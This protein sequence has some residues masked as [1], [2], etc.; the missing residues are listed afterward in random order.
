MPRFPLQA[1]LCP[2][3]DLLTISPALPFTRYRKAPTIAHFYDELLGRLKSMPQVES[4]S[5]TACLPFGGQ[6]MTQDVWAEGGG[7]DHRHASC[8]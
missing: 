6:L 1:N 7:R 2:Y 5:F 3:G 4:A 8:G